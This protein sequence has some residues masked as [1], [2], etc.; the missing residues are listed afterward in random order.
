MSASDIRY[1][2]R[3]VM[4]EQQ[5]AAAAFLTL[6]GTIVRAVP[7][8]NLGSRHVFIAVLRASSDTDI[9]GRI[10]LLEEFAGNYREIF[11]S[12]ELYMRR[13]VED[14][15][16]VEDIDRNGQKELVFAASS[17]GSS[18]GSQEALVCMYPF[19]KSSTVSA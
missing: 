10:H 17:F 8:R 7:Y 3:P 5:A 13:A 6:G 11:R 4:T 12:E 1:R 9:S 2:F 16:A 19:A 14:K 15:F 18:G